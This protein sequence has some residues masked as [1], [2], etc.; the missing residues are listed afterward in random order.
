MPL[1]KDAVSE[2]GCRTAYNTGISPSI[3]LET[4]HIIVVANNAS[5]TNILLYIAYNMQIQT[6]LH[7]INTTSILLPFTFHFQTPAASSNVRSSMFRGYL[8][9]RVRNSVGQPSDL[10]ADAR[11]DLL[12]KHL[13]IKW[14][15]LKLRPSCV[16]WRPK[17]LVAK[18][19]FP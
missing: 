10:L 19:P 8:K 17:W 6:I 9:Q 16:C 2:T 5:N 12:Q 7:V 1:L 14:N 11:A 4:S 13:T 3:E 15:R 18:P